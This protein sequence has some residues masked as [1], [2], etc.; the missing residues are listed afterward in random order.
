MSE[1]LFRTRISKPLKADYFRFLP[2]FLIAVVLFAGLFLLGMWKIDWVIRWIVRNITMV[3]TPEGRLIALRL[4]VL[5][6]TLIPFALAVLAGI[7]LLALVPYALEVHPDHLSV[8]TSLRRRKIPFR[9]LKGVKA[10]PAADFRKAPVLS[11][12]AVTLTMSSAGGVRL[13]R[14]TGA[15]YYM[16]LA[17]PNAFL[18]KCAAAVEAWHAG[19]QPGTAAP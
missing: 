19:K 2:H 7:W 16:G 3:D 9:E 14:R 10:V 1:P 4:T 17:A 11:K 8:V 13:E 6:V 15:D 12:R 18:S 5:M